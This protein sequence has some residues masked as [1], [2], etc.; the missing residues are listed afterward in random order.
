MKVLVV[1]AYGL[2]GGYVTA[3]L[4]AE[5]HAVIGVGRNIDVARR[6]VPGV[7][8]VRANLA[9]TTQDQ[10]AVHLANV[11]AVINCAGAL[12]DG[13][14]DDLEGVH[15]T[16]LLAL[17]RAAV[18]GGVR[19]FVHISAIGVAHDGGAFAATKAR[20]E[21]ALAALDLDWLI[22]RPGLVLAPA[23]Y[24]GSAL[25]R[26]LAAL[27]LLVPA[28]HGQSAVQVVS[29]HDVAACAARAIRPESP[30]R[31]RLSLAA[32]E[33]TTLADILRALRAWLGLAPAPVVSLP[34]VVARLSA[35]AADGLAWLGWRSPMRSAAIAQLRAG[36]RC[37]PDPQA[38]RLGF[39]P[40]SLADILATWPCG[41]QERWYARL[42]FLKPLVLVTL[43]GFWTASG[44]IG[45]ASHD[46]A[47]RQLTTAGFGEESAQ[48]IVLGG[49]VID[50][51]LGLLVCVRRAAPTALR[52]MILVTAGYLA[53]AAVW[54]PD[55]WADPL[56]PMVKAIPAAIL[57]LTALAMMDDR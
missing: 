55:L 43:A 16:G 50:L 37:D 29:A 42:Y 20:G 18:A 54:R 52:G 8:W 21:D 48:A 34:P 24:G 19:R 57:A 56:G 26:G 49:A 30:A 3:R 53:A 35:W 39:A 28:V 7:A 4:V 41:V 15:V 45:F 14:G 38:A 46:L 36:V 33:A 12:Q 27:P 32:S 51:T 10:W 31:L 17:A 13:P 5:G 44:L 40:R 22:L 9:T 2:I 6:R 47:A 1:G 11:D 23:A 25:L